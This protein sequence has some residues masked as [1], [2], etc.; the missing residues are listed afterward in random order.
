MK[1]IYKILILGMVCLLSTKTFAQFQAT[2]DPDKPVEGKSGSIASCICAEGFP[3]EYER[4]RQ[5]LLRQEAAERQQWLA[6]RQVAQKAEIERRLSKNYPNF[7]AAQADFLKEKIYKDPSNQ[8]VQQ[9]ISDY[10]KTSSTDKNI[11]TQRRISSNAVSHRRNVSDFSARTIYGDLKID[12]DLIKD[13]SGADVIFK[14]NQIASELNNV[15][16]PKANASSK[17]KNG[18]PKVLDRELLIDRLVHLSLAR[19]DSYSVEDKVKVMTKYLIQGEF[20][21]V[22]NYALLEAA[23]PYMF[24]VND[25]QYNGRQIA[26]NFANDIGTPDAIPDPSETGLEAVKLHAIISI[27]G[28][29]FNYAYSRPPLRDELGKFMGSQFYSDASIANLRR[30][31]NPFVQGQNFNGL[32]QDLVSSNTPPT[33]Q[34]ESNKELALSWKSD[35]PAT[36]L[37]NRGLGNVMHHLYNSVPRQFNLEGNTIRQAFNFN[38][39]NVPNNGLYSDENLGRI[40]DFGITPYGGKP[41]PGFYYNYEIIFKPSIGAI[42]WQQGITIQNM[43][44]NPLHMQAAINYANGVGGFDLEFEKTLEQLSQMLDLNISEV[45]SLRQDKPD[46]YI[47]FDHLRDNVFSEQALFESRLYVFNGHSVTP[48]SPSIGTIEG[49]SDFS[50]NALRIHTYKDG[51]QVTEFRL[52][53]GDFLAR[54]D[55]ANC[56]YCSESYQ[57]TMYLVNGGVEWFDVIV[58]RAYSTT[59]NPFDFVINKF[60][61]GAK[62]TGRYVIPV[63]D[64]LILIDGKNFDG[65]IENQYL[66]GGMIVVGFIPGGKL[67]KPIGKAVSGFGLKLIAKSGDDFLALG[68]KEGGEA[69]QILKNARKLKG[70][71]KGKGVKI[72]GKW[73]KG[74]HGNAGFFPEAIAKKMKGK[75]FNNFDE[76]REA[77]WKNVSDDPRLAD[78]FSDSNKALMKKGKAPKVSNTQNLGGQNTYQL[79]HKKPINQGGGVYDMDNLF[80]V[81]PRYHKEILLPAYHL[82]YGF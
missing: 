27:S 26:I 46:T 5:L 30:V 76:F 75:T 39:L 48:W 82:G 37:T 71:V 65:E 45:N 35:N 34:S 18:L 80:I 40:F 7:R 33:F 63:E 62:L 51:Q 43:F 77:F 21:S 68:I 72:N 12:G 4:F 41:G 69:F 22:D 67:L 61:D 54:G 42:L 52:D 74:T 3:E 57:R 6:E 9:L 20:F 81:T 1:S 13:Y 64:A 44:T 28:D 73:L 60:W 10:E 32:S 11:V 8:I 49:N 19:Y 79:H 36:A 59:E 66:A 17:I 23:P 58:P 24:N 31:V 38:G 2:P 70:V 55:Y 53:N 29:A 25:P 14:V 16:K 50:Y 15:H 47:I 56:P 78:Q